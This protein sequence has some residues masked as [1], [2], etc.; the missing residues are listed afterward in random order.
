MEA[1]NS[2]WVSLLTELR[3]KEKAVQEVIRQLVETVAPG[4]ELTTTAETM[5]MYEGG[6]LDLRNVKD[7]K[8]LASEL[9]TSPLKIWIIQVDVHCRED[10]GLK[11]KVSSFSD[12][13]EVNAIGGES[14]VRKRIFNSQ[15][16]Q[17][18]ELAEYVSAVLPRL[19][20]SD[21]SA[22]AS[23]GDA[24]ADPVSTSEECEALAATWAAEAM[25]PRY[26]APESPP[27][28]AIKE[29]TMSDIMAS[30]RRITET[31]EKSVK[32]TSEKSPAGQGAV[33][34]VGEAEA[35]SSDAP[36]SKA[37]PI[38]K[39]EPSMDEVLAGIRRLI[40]EEKQED[41]AGLKNEDIAKNETNQQ[42]DID[43]LKQKVAFLEGR[44]D[45]M[46][47]LLYLV[48]ESKKR[49]KKPTKKSG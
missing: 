22:P 42:R 24:L 20:G 19:I 9:G 47:R 13:W 26:K 14:L 31:D 27:A 6:F 40:F 2:C 38:T 28:K 18:G 43:A 16:R 4:A 10:A 39:P 32:T 29:P 3:A 5:I 15:A 8:A 46:S 48:I 37:A 35:S 30:I 11:F 33:Q 17:K 1:N 36:S 41:K 44:L 34:N 23:N 49:T 21:A 45:E 7:L 25:F 12:D